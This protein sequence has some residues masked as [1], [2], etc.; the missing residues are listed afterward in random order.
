M[1][2][3][4][5]LA[6]RTVSVNNL[7]TM[8][9]EPFSNPPPQPPPYGGVPPSMAPPGGMAYPPGGGMP[10]V[11]NYLVQSILVTLC[12]CLPFGIVAIVNAASVNTK[13]QQ[14]DFAGAQAASASAKK[15]C[16]YA[17]IAGAV[18]GLLYLLLTILGVGMG[19]LTAPS[20]ATPTP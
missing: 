9:D 17:L 8:P 7:P 18:V 11:P 2:P 3:K 6:P 19:A 20:S 13:L 16:T 15:W 12:C 10:P 1:C 4:L 5:R 14:G